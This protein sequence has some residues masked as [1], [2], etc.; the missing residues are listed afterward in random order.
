ML[1]YSNIQV[2]NTIDTYSI[3]LKKTKNLYK[4]ILCIYI[5]VKNT[6]LKK[7]I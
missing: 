6:I 5:Y 2:K 1:C 4:K 7:K 3:L